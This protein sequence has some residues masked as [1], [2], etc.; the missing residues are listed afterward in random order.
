MTR[1]DVI[2]HQPG[3]VQ[4]VVNVHV[5]ALKW[6]KEHTP[7]EIAEALPIEVVGTDK[8][9]YIKTLQKLREF[10]SSDGLINPQGV[11]NVY[12]S[13]V[14]SGAIAAGGLLILENF[15]TNAFSENSKTP[16]TGETKS[17]IDSDTSKSNMW[18]NINWPELLI[19]LFSGAV[20][21]AVIGWFISL[22]FYNK[23][24]KKSRLVTK[25]R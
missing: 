10:Y 21:G 1:Q 3:L 25:T 8:E 14:A 4:K 2:D 19:G 22:Y 16:K 11:E 13:M 5:R 17:V 7:E 18:N 6:I 20:I 24:E 12:R 23:Q 9:R 15:Y